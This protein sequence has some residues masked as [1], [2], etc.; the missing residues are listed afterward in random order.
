MG[1]Q[2]VL[3]LVMPG[4]VVRLRGLCRGH[5]VIRLWGLNALNCTCWTPG[6]AWMSRNCE[7]SGFVKEL[8]LSYLPPPTPQPRCP[9]SDQEVVGDHSN[10]LQ[11]CE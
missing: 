1:L 2:N 11:N 7:G 8:A 9:Q 3:Q 6:P 4:T 10:H 5:T